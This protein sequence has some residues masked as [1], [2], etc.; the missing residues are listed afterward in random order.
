MTQAAVSSC[1]SFLTG[2]S[3]DNYVLFDEDG[4]MYPLENFKHE[5]MPEDVVEITEEMA[6]ALINSGREIVPDADGCPAL[7]EATRPTP[8]QK[9]ASDTALRESLLAIASLR[10][11]LL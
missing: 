11:N 5:D 6:T 10:F 9:L 2:Q 7:A 3:G 8:K 1:L 4:E